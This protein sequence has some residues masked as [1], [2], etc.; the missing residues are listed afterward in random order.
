[1]ATTSNLLYEPVP[2]QVAHNAVS[3]LFITNPRLMNWARYMMEFSMPVAAALSDATA[4]W[5]S[6]VAKNETAFNIACDTNLPL[7]DY[8]AQTPGRADQFASY[9]QSVQASYGSNLKHLV[10]GFDWAGLGEADIVDVRL[11]L[12]E[13][14]SSIHPRKR[15]DGRDRLVAPPAAPASHSPKPS[16]SSASSSRI[17]RTPCPTARPCSP[18]SPSPSA[19]ASRRKVTTSSPPS[20]SKVPLPTFSARSCMTGLP[21]K[22]SRF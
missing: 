7:F 12:P 3:A 19:H 15:I 16:P 14:M 1:M 18:L 21:R 4:K 22:R 8:L 20:P 11:S 2:G 6:T 9:M 10:T 5:G 17:C 13:P